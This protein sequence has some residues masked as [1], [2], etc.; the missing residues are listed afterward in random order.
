VF[1]VE[2]PARGTIADVKRLLCLPP[3]SVCSDASA[4]ELVLKG[5]GAA[6][7]RAQRCL[8]CV[9]T[10][11]S[12]LWRAGCIMR[13]D[14]ALASAAAMQGVMLTAMLLVSCSFPPRQSA[15]AAA[16]A[17]SGSVFS[18]GENC[19]TRRSNVARRLARAHRELAGKAAEQWTNGCYLR[20]LRSGERAV[21]C[22][23]RRQRRGTCFPNIDPPGKPLTAACY[24]Y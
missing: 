16:T 8:R 5:E 1:V 20:R 18:C 9:L 3:H 4:L 24:Q 12:L 2:A 21:D 15:S 11:I 10:R 17:A 19:R 13:D 14:A 6:V 7:A 23:S 22:C